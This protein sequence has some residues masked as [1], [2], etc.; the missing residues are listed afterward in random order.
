MTARALRLIEEKGLE[1]VL[2]PYDAIYG[3]VISKDLVNEETGEIYCEAGTPIDA[4]LLKVIEPILDD[5][6]E[7]LNTDSC[8]VGDFIL[9]TILN[10]K[11]L[12]RDEALCELYSSLVQ[13][14]SP[15]PA[16]GE[17]LLHSMLWNTDKYDLSVVG[18]GK[19]NDRLG[20][21]IP[22]DIRTLQKQDILGIIKLLC[23]V[24]NGHGEV[25]DIDNLGNRRIRSAG[26]L[27]KNWLH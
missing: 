3:K 15:T 18:R 8:D 26:E 6:I 19:I 4:D 9:K 5:K 22:D 20:I 27:K 10:T 13:E 12:N 21:N 24:K 2:V 14:E 16:M 17:E 7:V 1:H 25:D 11:C 23:L